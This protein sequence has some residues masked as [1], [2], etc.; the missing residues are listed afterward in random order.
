MGI[1]QDPLMDQG[2]MPIN[3]GVSARRS[4]VIKIVQIVEPKRILGRAVPVLRLSYQA[5]LVKQLE[6][7]RAGHT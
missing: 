4:E 7:L 6:A 5:G 3:S 2:P 1:L